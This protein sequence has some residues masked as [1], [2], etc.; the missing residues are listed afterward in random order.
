MIY[1]RLLLL[2]LHIRISRL[3]FSGG[4]K[5]LYVNIARGKKWVGLSDFMDITL[6]KFICKFLVT[7]YT[8]IYEF[9]QQF[10]SHTRQIYIHFFIHPIHIYIQI[11]YTIFLSHF[12][13]LYTNFINNFLVTLYKFIKKLYSPYPHLYTNF[14]N[15]FFVTLYKFIYEFL[16]L[17]GVH[18]KRLR[19]I[20]ITTYM[21]TSFHKYIQQA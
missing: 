3:T 14:I 6:Y 17:E 8:F 10:F 12:I 20:G 18:G 7:R 13:H 15:I 1:P 5:T 4:G 9:Y 11:L 19:E 16:V 21:D 2:L